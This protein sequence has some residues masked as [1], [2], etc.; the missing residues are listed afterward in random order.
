M[1]AAVAC[2][3]RNFNLDNL[4]RKGNQQNE[5]LPHSQTPLHQEPPAR[6]GAIQKL[7]EKLI[8]KMKNCCHY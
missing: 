6:A 3:V 8:E 1:E 7:K 4:G 5:A 2:V